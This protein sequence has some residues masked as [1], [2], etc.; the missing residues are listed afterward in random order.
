MNEDKRGFF[1]KARDYLNA[2]RKAI[3]A[4]VSLLLVQE[5]DSETADWI[6]SATGVFFTLITPNDRAAAFRIYKK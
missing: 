4:G 5:V 2:H 3:I 6:V 1:A